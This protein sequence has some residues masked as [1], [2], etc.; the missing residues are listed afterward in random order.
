MVPEITGYEPL[1]RFF[2]AYSTETSQYFL[3][4]WDHSSDP[5]HDRHVYTGKIF[6]SVFVSNGSN[7]CHDAYSAIC[8]IQKEPGK[9]PGKMWSLQE[10]V[11]GTS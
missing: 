10:K 6:L 3:Q 1:G 8:I 9:M 4:D 2:H 7:F 5:A 11:P